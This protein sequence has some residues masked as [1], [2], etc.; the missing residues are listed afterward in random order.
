MIFNG[1]LADA[2]IRGDVLAGMPGENEIEN[3]PPTR[4]QAIKMRGGDHSPFRRW[5]GTRSIAQ[6]HT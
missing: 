2:Q 6:A 1:A 5:T 3:L 4:R